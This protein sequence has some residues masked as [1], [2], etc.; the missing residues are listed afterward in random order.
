ME[1]RRS[2]WEC[3]VSAH[4][5]WTMCNDW[6]SVTEVSL[7]PDKH[8]P[9]SL[10]PYYCVCTLTSVPHHST[11]HLLNLLLKLGCSATQPLPSLL[12]QLHIT[13]A[14]GHGTCVSTRH[15]SSTIGTPRAQYTLH[16]GVIIGYTTWPV[17]ETTLTRNPGIVKKTLACEPIVHHSLPR[18]GTLF[19]HMWGCPV[20]SLSPTDATGLSC[21]N[22]L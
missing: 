6:Y 13:L 17:Q 5:G 4:R 21:Q 16:I 12:L 19:T 15:E 8:T 7:W 9:F 2:W 10:H 20:R 1:E 14:V 11:W 3:L 22:C 18:S